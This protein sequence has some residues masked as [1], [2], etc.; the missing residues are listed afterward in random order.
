MAKVFEVKGISQCV[1]FDNGSET[2]KVGVGGEDSP[3]TIFPNI[4]GRPRNGITKDNKNE[5]LLKDSYVGEE[6]QSKREFLRIRF[7][8]ENG[9]VT[10]F[11]D[12]EK[13]WYCA[14]NELNLAPEENTVLL[15]EDSLNPRV[16]REKITQMFFET[17]NVP[18]MYSGDKA[19]LSLYASGRSTGIVFDSGYTNTSII[20]VYEGHTIPHLIPRVG[21]GGYDIH[22]YLLKISCERGYAWST[23]KENRIIKDYLEKFAYV[24]L[25]FDQE[26]EKA[27]SASFPLKSYEL[28]N[29]N[30]IEFGNERFRCGEI[31]FQPNM[32]C[33]DKPGV[34][35]LIFHTISLCDPEI[36]DDLYSNIILSGGNTMFPGI[37]DRLHNELTKLTPA[38]TD[39]KIIAPL[40]RM[41]SAWLGG[42]ILSTNPNFENMCIDR[43]EYEEYGPSYIH[44]KCY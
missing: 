39:I 12:M 43:Q 34:H 40:N 24:A 42:S 11:D 5:P 19:V 9:C 18:S 1:V 26:L 25:D 17:Y 29:G 2:M 15:T 35:E 22:S 20:P 41:T 3:R 14:Y 28:P 8:Y 37:E 33:L 27:S 6:A 36:R 32:I 30:T 23:Y 10:N 44:W 21:F 31:I 38:N 13:V 16:N 4:V 7:P